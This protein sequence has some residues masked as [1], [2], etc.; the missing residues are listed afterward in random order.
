MPEKGLPHTYKLLT[1]RTGKEYV[2]G[3][4]RRW[5]K[6]KS[7]LH[8]CSLANQHW[9]LIA[10][11]IRYNPLMLIHIL[12]NQAKFIFRVQLLIGTTPK[13]LPFW[14]R[15]N[16]SSNTVNAESFIQ[17]KLFK[18]I[19]FSLQSNNTKYDRLCIPVSFL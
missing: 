13:L 14:T 2:R 9:K 10:Q 15:G 4:A 11:N 5:T 7:V 8:S 16:K 1:L 18:A 19:I 3:F 12:E 17:L 6:T